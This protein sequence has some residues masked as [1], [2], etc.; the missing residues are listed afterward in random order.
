[1]VGV[2][3]EEAAVVVV[4]DKMKKDRVGLGWRPE[5]ASSIFASLDK[6][7]VLEV[8][9]NDRLTGDD[10]QKRALKSLA[11]EVPLHIHG[12]D[13]GLAGAEKVEGKRLDR[14]AR[15][16]NDVQPE[17][18]SEHLAFVRAGGREIGHLAAPPRT[19]ESVDCAVWNVTRAA[20]TV[21]RTPYMENIATLIQPPCSSL[22]ESQ[23]ISRIITD[24]EC[25]LLLDLHNVHAN[26]TN[27]GFDPLLFLEEIPLDRVRCIH[28]AGGKWISSG[29]GGKQYLLDDHL[30][31]TP[32]PVYEL[33]SEVAARTEQPLTVILERDGAYP[34]MPLLLRE[35]EMARTAMAIGRAR[36]VRKHAS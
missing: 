32:Q 16:V 21:G 30:H 15:L 5:L 4:E 24:S 12:V 27:F 28:I 2:A 7:D 1:M 23:W 17:A 14:F 20:K 10:Q 31:E 26:A 8:L 35:L 18:W 25:G 6:I 34:E 19:P 22:T 29:D 11:R 33:L 36:K 9:G 3:A 13:L